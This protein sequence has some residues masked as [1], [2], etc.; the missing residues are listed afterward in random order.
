MM[1]LVAGI[2]VTFFQAGL[3]FGANERLDVYASLKGDAV[4]VFVHGGA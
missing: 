4:H 2:V 3:V 1:Y